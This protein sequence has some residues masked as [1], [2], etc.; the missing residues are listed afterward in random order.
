MLLLPD[1]PE[2]AFT[3]FGAIKIGSVAVPVNTLLKPHDYEYLLNDSRARALVVHAR[4]LP[5]IDPIR[6]SLR[7]LQH[8]LV[9]GD[10]QGDHSYPAALES[11]DEHLV[12]EAMSDDDAA[13]LA[14]LVGNDGVSQGRHPP[15]A[16]HDLLR[17]SVRPRR[18][19]DNGR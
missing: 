8:V 3:F 4:L 16:R 17:G 19:R 14:V 12:A 9:V 15:A 6:S 18:A 1:G 7:Y 11:E 10:A 5:V 2:F 13:V